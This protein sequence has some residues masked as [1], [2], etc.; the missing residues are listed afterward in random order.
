MKNQARLLLNPVAC[1]G[2]GACAELFPEWIAA[3]KWGYPV[4]S[5]DPI[6]SQLIQHAERAVKACPKLALTIRWSR[7]Q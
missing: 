7:P 3:D 2:F 5:G 1:D 4:I 6:P